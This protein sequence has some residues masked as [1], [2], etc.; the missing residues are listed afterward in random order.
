[1]EKKTFI[2]E[3]KSSSPITVKG[4]HSIKIPGN[5]SG[6]TAVHTALPDDAQTAKLISRLRRE[7]PALVITEQ[8]TVTPPA[9]AQTAST[10][11]DTKA[12][13]K[14]AQGAAQAEPQ[15]EA[16]AGAQGKED[17]KAKAATNAKKGE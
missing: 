16:L 2:I 13:G 17:T 15:P 7:Y 1:M 5:V 10:G 14:P 12:E 9:A 8:K 11:V 3:N 4:R 6:E